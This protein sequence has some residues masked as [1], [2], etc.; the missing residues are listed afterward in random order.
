MAGLLPDAGTIAVGVMGLA[1]QISSPSYMVPSSFGSATAVR[2]ANLLGAGL[3]GKARLA[4]RVAFCVIL[5]C[6]LVLGSG[7]YLARHWIVLVFTS[8]LSIRDAT[9]VVVPAVAT[10]LVG[11]GM[12]AVLSSVLRACGRQA[13]GALMNVIGYWVI[14]LPLAYLF[15][16]VL[17]YGVLGFW[18][19]LT[20]STAFQSV[21]FGVL[22]WRLN[23]DQEVVRA[24]A[25][26][27]AHHGD[28]HG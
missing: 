24:R 26:T 2:V 20:L 13:L 23:W 22:I 7:T 3:P 27:A 8:D 15:G 16:F 12:V 10:A 21:V 1:I 19:A 14:C 17:G 9:A 6:M 5:S 4:S 11:D 25:L 18:I 28:H